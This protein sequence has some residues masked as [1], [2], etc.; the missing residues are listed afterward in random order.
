MFV[1]VLCVYRSLQQWSREVM[2]LLL[3]VMARVE[4]FFSER[5]H[6]LCNFPVRLRSLCWPIR[7]MLRLPGRDSCVW[8][9][10]QVADF[11]APFAHK[12][13]QLHKQLGLPFAES[14]SPAV[15]DVYL[16]GRLRVHVF[17]RSV[18]ARFFSSCALKLLGFWMKFGAAE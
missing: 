11:H 1:P 17:L 4:L 2:R 9:G 18:K 8:R 7:H 5:L 15:W 3:P 10:G 6:V 16:S 12:Y 13:K 14:G